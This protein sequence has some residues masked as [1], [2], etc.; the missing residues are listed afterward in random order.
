MILYLNNKNF[1][2]VSKILLTFLFTT[3]CQLD[4][5][6][7]SIRSKLF[8]S[9]KSKVIVNREEET[10]DEK[11]LE[12]KVKVD[13]K[14][15]KKELKEN[16]LFIPD[17][18]EDNKRILDFFKLDSKKKENE[19]TLF[20]QDKIEDDK[21]I[22]DFFTG[23]F[24]SDDKESKNVETSEI[25]KSNE[26]KIV[27]KKPTEKFKIST[28]QPTE[29]ITENNELGEVNLDKVNDEKDIV[30]DDYADINEKDDS[31]NE[32]NNAADI[33]KKNDVS[34]NEKDNSK[35]LNND[36]TKEQNLAFFNIQR[37][38][39]DTEKKISKKR[40]NYVG[41]LLPLTGDKRSAG[42]LVL[43]TFRYSLIDNPMDVVFKIYDTK[44]TADGVIDAA[45]KGKKDNVKTFIGPIFSYETK[46]LKERFVDDNSI[47]FFSL[48]P[49]LSNV[50]ENIIVS[51]QNL[52]DQ[53]SCIVSDLKIK[54]I[55]ELLLI[56]HKDRYGDIIKKSIQKNLSMLTE[57]NINLSLLEIDKNKDLNKEI[58]SISNFDRRK[59]T[60]KNQKNKIS[61]DKDLSK[62]EKKMMLKKLDRQLT[63]D[64]P[65]DAI[66]VASEGDKLLEI[67]SHLAFYDINANNTLIYGTSLWEDTFKTDPVFENTFFVTNLKKRSESFTKNYQDVFSK[68]PT[69]LNFHLFDLIDFVNEFKVYDEYPEN[70]IHVGRF[71][72]S[73][74]KSGSLRRETYI[75][76]N[77][78]KNNTQ[79]ISS[80]RLDII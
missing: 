64:S 22:L 7:D 60:L 55:S 46:A 18:T 29:K 9:E 30:L 48:S 3:S 17:K 50:S 10:V 24:S 8:E 26:E 77:K 79:D 28:N 49:D 56:N 40:N 69:S 67:L 47:V 80:C 34:N 32:K 15:K 76:K 65:F 53:I 2:Q 44:G 70:K 57:K 4:Q 51:G 27:L 54:N 35:E 59:D 41:L 74:V 45:I 52:E 63:I 21:R 72:N 43:N 75:K 66:I 19:D 39:K 68:N 36:K 37:P 25:V 1:L 5:S 38:K 12:K 31:I 16:Q 11:V 14:I 6:L 33:V 42:S 61:A 13:K 78:G 23:F 58:R 73:Q 20:T 62:E 71:T